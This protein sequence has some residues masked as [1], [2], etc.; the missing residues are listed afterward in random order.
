LNWNSIIIGSAAI[1]W[2]GAILAQAGLWF[3]QCWSNQDSGGSLC[4][5]GCCLTFAA[6]FV[7]SAVVSGAS[8]V[9]WVFPGII[10]LAGLAFLIEAL[11]YRWQDRRAAAATVPVEDRCQ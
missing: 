7:L 2:L 3:G 1:L 11:N 8:L 10:T 6:P 5:A 9:V 4:P